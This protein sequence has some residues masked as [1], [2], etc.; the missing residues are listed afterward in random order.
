V[1]KE[2]LE[3]VRSEL[4]LDYLD[5]VAMG[6]EAM[7]LLKDFLHHETVGEKVGLQLNRSKF[8]VIGH[9]RDTGYVHIIRH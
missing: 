7:Y 5:D 6:V 8:E 9:H 3:S 4:V 2:L 1:F